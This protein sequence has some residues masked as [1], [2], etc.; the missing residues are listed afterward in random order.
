MPTQHALT[1]SDI[2]LMQ[3]QGMDISPYKVGQQVS[4]MNDEEYGQYQQD[5]QT[6]Q[7]GRLGAVWSNLRQN[8]GSHLGGGAA[9]TVGFGTGMAF[10]EGLAAL[11]APETMG[12]SLLI[13]P[14]LGAITAAG[15]G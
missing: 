5:E 12:L 2:D 4:V 11:A 7:K 3:Q 13:P 6:R 10:G 9:G 8:I 14:L 15:T 1:Q